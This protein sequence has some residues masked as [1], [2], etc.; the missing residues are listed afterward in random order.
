MVLST[1]MISQDNSATII[2]AGTMLS[3]LAGGDMETAI[4]VANLQAVSNDQNVP[5]VAG[6]V[7]N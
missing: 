5:S 7:S 6:A 1:C 2:P 3:L 4:G